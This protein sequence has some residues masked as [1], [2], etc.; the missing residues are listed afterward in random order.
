MFKYHVLAVFA[1]LCVC[2]STAN[3][4][5]NDSCAL[6]VSCT[7]TKSSAKL[8]L[9]QSL[10]DESFHEINFHE[11]DSA[12]QITAFVPSLEVAN[13]ITS[14]G[15]RAIFYPSKGEYRADAKE[16][17]DLSN[18][19]PAN[20]DADGVKLKMEFAGSTN[21]APYHSIVTG[22]IELRKIRADMFDVPVPDLVGSTVVED[23]DKK[24]SLLF[25]FYYSD[26]ALN[27]IGSDLSGVFKEQ[28]GM[29][30]GKYG[31]IIYSKKSAEPDKCGSF[32]RQWVAEQ[33]VE[34]K[35]KGTQL[36]D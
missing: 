11:F 18:Q 34:T 19:L 16:L 33:S 24:T 8:G 15:Y 35:Q 7:D 21:F 20:V 9:F 28:G 22:N 14:K 29:F 3:Q 30:N 6:I 13:R 26:R 4:A 36:N 1:C 12:D 17:S 10:L 23:T 32:L 25:V 2:M 5:D 31:F 27:E